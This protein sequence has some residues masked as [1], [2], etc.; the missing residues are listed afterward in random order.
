MVVEL[1]SVDGLVVGGAT[2]VVAIDAVD[3]E[4]TVVVVSYFDMAIETS[5]G[6][7][8]GA[9]VVMLAAPKTNIWY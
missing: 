2:E 7:V 4:V 6:I 1:F 8:S 3:A 5:N 9:G